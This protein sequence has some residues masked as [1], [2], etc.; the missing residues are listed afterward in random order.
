M[1]L[2]A[3]TSPVFCSVILKIASRPIITLRGPTASIDSA[4]V[5]PL[6]S[7]SLPGG[8]SDAGDL[9][10]ALWCIGLLFSGRIVASGCFVVSGSVIGSGCVVASDCSVASG[11][12]EAAAD[13]RDPVRATLGKGNDFVVAEKS[14][15]SVSV[16]ITSTASGERATLPAGGNFDSGS[17]MTSVRGDLNDL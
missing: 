12:A 2:L 8:V 1:T 11:S 6:S 13:R 4:G 10:G 14:A 16:S 17:L 5:R 3:G 9:C 7:S 15:S